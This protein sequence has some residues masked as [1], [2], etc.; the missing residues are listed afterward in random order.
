MPG[1]GLSALPSWTG[2]YPLE[3]VLELACSRVSILAAV[4]V[5]VGGGCAL[6][7]SADV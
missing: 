1:G 3:A 4:V 5:V 2:P 6:P 7:V